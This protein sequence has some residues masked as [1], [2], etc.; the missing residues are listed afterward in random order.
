MPDINDIRP[1]SI[2]HIIGQKH[3]REV[4][5]LGLDYAHQLGH[6]FDHAMLVGPPGLGKTAL[7]QIIAQEMATDFTELL[8]QSFG[9]VADLN[10]VLLT[11]TERS[12]VFID[13][14]HEM[15]KSL[16]TTLYL[17]LDQKKILIPGSKNGAAPMS[18]PIQ[19][20]TLLLATTDEYLLLQPLRDR[21]KL[22][23]RFEFYSADELTQ[24]VANRSRGLGWKVEEN[25]FPAIASKGRGTPRL[26]LRLLE[27]SH[28]V[29]RAEGDHIITFK[30]LERACGL[31]QI[32]S[33]GLGPTEQKY[34]V[35]IAESP[36]RLNVIASML[37][38][39]T[40]TVSEVTE[41]YLQR[42]GLIVKDDQGRRQLTEKGRDHLSNCSHI[43][44]GIPSN[45]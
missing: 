27:S 39:P 5:A 30:H 44:V 40:R 29:C 8:G 32:D 11:A 31:E 41:P 25:V 45:E 18:I 24:I 33:L 7:S 9:S 2:S 10:A 20:F 4:V 37:G 43:R 3:V 34:L 6:K 19:D 26:A 12:I 17:A 16:Q 42:A 38:L 36:T 1:T 15:N 23:L 35:I 28:R 14:V 21:M 13:E 22:T